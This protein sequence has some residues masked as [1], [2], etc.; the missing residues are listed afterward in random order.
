MNI[1]PLPAIRS[2]ESLRVVVDASIHT[3]V[4]TCAFGFVSRL[5]VGLTLL[6]S[7]SLRM[8]HLIIWICVIL[9]RML[10]QH[11]LFVFILLHH[12]LIIINSLLSK[13]LYIN[14]LGIALI[15]TLKLLILKFEFDLRY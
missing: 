5:L 1:K 12:F 4:E 11:Q 13:L 15:Q 6:A 3:L 8:M 2:T 7:I 14:L 10:L 9:L